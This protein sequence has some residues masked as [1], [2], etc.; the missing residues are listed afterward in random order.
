MLKIV[1]VTK[2][3]SRFFYDKRELFSQIAAVFS[4][5]IFLKMATYFF[6]YFYIEN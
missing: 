1:R 4:K 2:H 3:F 6:I 5:L